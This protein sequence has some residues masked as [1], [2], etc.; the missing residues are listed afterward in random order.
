MMNRTATYMALVCFSGVV[1]ALGCGGN[2]KPPPNDPST[3]SGIQPN[4]P[5]TT[6]TSTSTMPATRAPS[7]G[8]GNTPGNPSSGTPSL[9][10]SQTDN[11]GSMSQSSSST[12]ASGSSLAQDRALSEGQVLY[13][14]HSANVGE[15]DQARTAVQKA[16]N[17][18]VKRFADMMLKDHGDADNKG[19]EVASRA[20]TSPAPS[21]V[22]KTLVSDASQVTS[23]LGAQSAGADFDRAYIESQVKQ[24]SAL[25]DIIDK[26]LLPNAKNTDVREFVQTI[27]AKVDSHLKEAQDIQRGLGSK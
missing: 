14:L 21:E 20:R 24:H 19:N 22:S 9:A 13:I 1:G 25:L 4:P 2:D 3:V 27:R 10:A 26:Q 6:E 15:M 23:S 8:V 7:S 11:Q 5:S 18:R 12:T 17:A 16:K